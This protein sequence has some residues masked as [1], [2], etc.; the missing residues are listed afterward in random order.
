MKKIPVSIIGT[1]IEV[2]TSPA[3]ETY[4]PSAAEDI[5][6]KEIRVVIKDIKKKSHKQ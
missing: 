5:Q 1:G 4:Q 3:I 6:M 2:G